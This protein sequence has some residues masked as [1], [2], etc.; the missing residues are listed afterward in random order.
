VRRSTFAYETATLARI[1]SWLPALL[2]VVAS[3]VA[4]IGA[5]VAGIARGGWISG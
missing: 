5:L 3:V 4:G 1:G 2:N